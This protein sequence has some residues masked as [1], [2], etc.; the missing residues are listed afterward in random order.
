MRK[1]NP[2]LYQAIKTYVERHYEKEGRSPTVRE[3][4]AG[5][6]ITRPTVQRYLTAMRESGEI[7]YNGIRGVRTVVMSKTDRETAAVAMIGAVACGTPIYA[8]ENIQEY[9]RFP[10]ALLGQG[11]FFLLRA[12]GE[13][14]I[15]AGI[16]DGDLLLVRQQNTA[17]PGQ[18]VVALIDD[19]ATLKR[20]YPEPENQRIRLHPENET[21]EDIYVENCLVQGIAV[22]VLKHLV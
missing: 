12:K 9:Y 7:E 10:V 8:E 3:I 18:I 22:K 4:E 14:M 15:N 19:E 13:S 16:G 20:F 6:G 2:E 21:M 11:N 5:T 17:E 1:K